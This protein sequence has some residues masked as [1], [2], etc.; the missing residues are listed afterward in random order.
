MN[1]G[2]N[3]LGLTTDQRGA[4]FPRV[5]GPAADIGA[6]EINLPDSIFEDHF[7]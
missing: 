3:P 1:A 4:P 7:E 5:S 6:F 2:S